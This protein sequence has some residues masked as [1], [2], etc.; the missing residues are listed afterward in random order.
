MNG[1]GKH[2]KVLEIMI[3]HKISSLMA[4]KLIKSRQRVNSSMYEEQSLAKGH[5]IL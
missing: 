1:I 3:T 4:G 2:F 5:I